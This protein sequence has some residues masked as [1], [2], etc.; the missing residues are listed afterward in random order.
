MTFSVSENLKNNFEKAEFKWSVDKGKI[1]TGQG[2]SKIE[3]DTE[4]VDMTGHAAVVNVTLEIS[5]LPE[6]C[7]KSFSAIGII[8]GGHSYPSDQYGKLSLKDELARLDAFISD[9]SAAPETQ[10][11]VVFSLQEKKK[12]KKAENHARK[13][14]KRF[15][16][17]GIAAERITFLLDKDQAGIETVLWRIPKDIQFDPFEGCEVIK[18]PE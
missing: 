6:N 10:G 15:K 1:I 4:S 7:K 8:I 16:N 11:Y 5:V 14:L 18:V 3:I 12:K 13:L 9:L 2:T 17:R